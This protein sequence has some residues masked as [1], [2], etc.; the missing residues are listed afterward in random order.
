M[1]LKIKVSLQWAGQLLKKCLLK[2]TFQDRK[3]NTLLKTS[4]GVNGEYRFTALDY[5]LPQLN[6]DY[7]SR[8][9]F[10]GF[11]ETIQGYCLGAEDCDIKDVVIGWGIKL[12]GCYWPEHELQ[13]CACCCGC[14][15]AGQWGIVLTRKVSIPLSV[16]GKS[17]RIARESQWRISSW[18]LAKG[19]LI[20][21]MSH[22]MLL[23]FITE[24][25]TGSSNN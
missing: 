11:R 17:L 13:N 22:R 12:S 3:L 8:F 25:S 5:S 15:A 2:A 6:A 1:K 18:V 23:L 24:R 16:P 9:R 7:K 4:K 14:R 19:L 21:Q 20:K 10:E